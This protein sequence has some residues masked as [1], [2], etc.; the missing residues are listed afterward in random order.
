MYYIYIH[1]TPPNSVI[2]ISSFDKI[3][4]PRLLQVCNMLGLTSVRHRSRE[5]CGVEGRVRC[6]HQRSDAIKTSIHK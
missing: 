5:W 2:L 6:L 1:D 4:D 3:F